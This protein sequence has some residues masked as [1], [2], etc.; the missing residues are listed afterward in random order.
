MNEI[1][2]ISTFALLCIAVAYA[3]RYG[4]KYLYV[5]SVFIIL[6]SNVTVGIQV[7]IF[8]VAV[9]LGVIIYSIVYLVTDVISEH[10]EKNEAYKLALTNIVVQI[11]FWVYMFLSIQTTPSGGEAAYDAMD[12]MFSSTAR[13]TVAALV[14]SLGAFADIWFYEWLLGRSRKKAEDSDQAPKLWFRNIAST[15]FGQSINTA[16]FFTIAL[17][18]VVPNLLSIIFSAIAI[19]WVIA[20]LDTPF[21]YWA[22]GIRKNANS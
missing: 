11:M 20:L 7:N 13:I 19:K 8:G 4:L 10:F 6:A 12:T 14:A 17:Y 15:F 16:I 3:A 2:A 18:G 5:V 9:S 1:I 21:L 22:C